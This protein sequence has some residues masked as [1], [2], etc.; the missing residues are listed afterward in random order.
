MLRDTRKYFKLIVHDNCYILMGQC[1]VCSK[2]GEFNA[3]DTNDLMSDLEATGLADEI[4]RLR[5][6]NR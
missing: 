3:L 4:H 2:E 6:E 1:E 5:N